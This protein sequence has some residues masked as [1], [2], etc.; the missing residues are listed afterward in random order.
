LAHR[1]HVYNDKTKGELCVRFVSIPLPLLHVCCAF[2]AI[3]SARRYASAVYAVVVCPSVRP[4]FTCRYCDLY[5]NG[6]I[7]DH[8]N[9]AVR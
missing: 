1:V 5:L 6:Q 7:C 4:S 8:A 2:D 9:N 3:I